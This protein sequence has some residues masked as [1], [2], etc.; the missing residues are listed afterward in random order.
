[1]KVQLDLGSEENYIW[2]MLTKKKKLK[3]I[4]ALICKTTIFIYIC[5]TLIN[6][7]GHL[8]SLRGG[9]GL[10]VSDPRVEK[11]TFVK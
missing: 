10:H 8:F 7:T 2:S 1:M 9:G 6:K 3:V 11:G 4:I 5:S